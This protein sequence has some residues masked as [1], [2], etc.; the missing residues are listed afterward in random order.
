MAIS[1]PKHLE[2]L[3]VVLRCYDTEFDA[4]AGRRARCVICAEDI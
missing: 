3:L 4:L 2:R 1:G